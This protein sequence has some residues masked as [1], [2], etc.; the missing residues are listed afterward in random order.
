MNQ[1]T[2]KE[3]RSFLERNFL[4][5]C[6]DLAINGVQVE[7]KGEVKNII[8]AV[9]FSCELIY[10][11]LKKA[12]LEKKLLPDLIL[13]HHG[14][15][16]GKQF[17]LTGRYFDLIEPLI[18]NNI[19]LIGLHIPLDIHPKMGN[20][21]LL[22]EKLN[23]NYLEN[24]GNYEGLKI[25]VKGEYSRPVLL[26]EFSDLIREKVGTLISVV[27]SGETVRVVG[28]CTGG[29]HFGIEEASRNGCDTFITGDAK[30]T[31]YHLAKELG[32]NLIQAGH[33]NTE[34]LGIKKLGETLAEEFNLKHEFIDLPTR[35]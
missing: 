7:K 14:I 26:D 19:G 29:G 13:V 20:N 33:Y 4:M 16:W 23:L 17:A 30:H 27:K 34:V 18:K 11:I 8:T 22:L 12:E 24:F 3:I 15:F 31:S 32:I 25:L 6:P 21:V 1:I 9:D 10:K 5:N 28:L 35:L 2:L